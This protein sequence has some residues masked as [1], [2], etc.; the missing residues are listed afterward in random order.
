MRCSRN[1]KVILVLLI[2]VLIIES[3]VNLSKHPSHSKIHK[4]LENSLNFK[5]LKD[6][7]TREKLKKNAKIDYLL[8]DTV[9]LPKPEHPYVFLKRDSHAKPQESHSS[10]AI[11]VILAI[12]II[13]IVIGVIGAVIY[14]K[15]KPKGRKRRLMKTKSKS[16]DKS[17]IDKIDEMF[18]GNIGVVMMGKKKKISQILK[19]QIECNTEKDRELPHINCKF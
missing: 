3:K 12:L 14:W 7:K 1:L 19:N 10:S 17:Y 9:T 16:K 15:F 11:W 4:K 8:R 6:K 5:E 18:E 2:I 13:I